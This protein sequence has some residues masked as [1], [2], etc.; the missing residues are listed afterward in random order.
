MFHQYLHLFIPKQAN[1][2]FHKVIYRA[3]DV[4]GLNQVLATNL[5]SDGFA[6]SDT[7]LNSDGYR[8]VNDEILLSNLVP[9]LFGSVLTYMPKLKKYLWVFNRLSTISK[10]SPIQN[11][12]LQWNEASVETISGLEGDW[13]CFFYLGMA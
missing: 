10:I 6:N 8:T 7:H 1:I 3:I 12:G 9:E 5:N 11:M 2:T 13:G 4:Q